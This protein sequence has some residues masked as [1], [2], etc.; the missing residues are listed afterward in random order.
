MKQTLECNNHG[1]SPATYVCKHLLE[2]IKT[3]QPYGFNWMLDEENEIQA[4][5]D[6]CWNADDEEW[7]KI[8]EEGSRLLCL[9]C[10]QDV[11]RMNNL[12]MELDD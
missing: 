9:S 5:C 7:E 11:A 6:N 4:F 1:K 10:L 12:E 3:K 8:S 2:T